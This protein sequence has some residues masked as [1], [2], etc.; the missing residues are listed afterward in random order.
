ML[1][2]LR[3]ITD[4]TSGLFMFRRN[5]IEGADLQPIGWKIMVEVLAMGTYKT[6]RRVKAVFEGHHRVPE[7]GSRAYKKRQETGGYHCCQMV[8][9]KTQE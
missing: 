2:S 6:C 1:P 8:R 9:R 4:P 7:A 3:K 5:V